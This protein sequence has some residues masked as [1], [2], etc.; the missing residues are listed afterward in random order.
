M[1]V[2]P[3]LTAYWLQLDSQV[4]PPTLAPQS[5]LTGSPLLTVQGHDFLGKVSVD[6]A[7]LLNERPDAKATDSMWLPLLN[8]KGAKGKGELRIGLE[9]LSAAQ[10][11]QVGLHPVSQV[12]S[13]DRGSH[14]LQGCRDTCPTASA[15]GCPQGAIELGCCFTGSRTLL[16]VCSR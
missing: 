12:P 10:A 6:L 13:S 3:L 14:L 1:Q 16:A 11:Q 8:R 15:L 4:Q 5:M 9:F 7:A 2:R